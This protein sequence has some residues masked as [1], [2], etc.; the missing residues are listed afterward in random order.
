MSPRSKKAANHNDR[1]QDACRT[2]CGLGAPVNRRPA[3]RLGRCRWPVVLRVAAVIAVVTIGVGVW[4]HTTDRP[5]QTLT[6]LALGLTQ[7]AVALGARARP[8][9]AANPMLFAAVGA[10]VLLQLA[11]IYA[12]PLRQLLGTEPVA[13]TDLLIVMTVSALGYVAIRLDRRIHSTP[14]PP[15]VVGRPISKCPESTAGRAAPENRCDQTDP[16]CRNSP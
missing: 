11:A 5:W 4:A 16:S 9:T 13:A 3:P 8:G 2:G 6:F 10:A 12:P 14:P 15:A 1:S 7:L